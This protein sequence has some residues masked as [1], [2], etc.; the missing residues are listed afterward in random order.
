MTLCL[1]CAV[2]GTSQRIV[3]VVGTNGPMWVV[4]LTTGRVVHVWHGDVKGVHE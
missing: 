2:S 3:E 1:R 4:R